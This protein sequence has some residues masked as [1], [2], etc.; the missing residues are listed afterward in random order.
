MPEQTRYR[1]TFD[2]IG[3]THDVAPLDVTLEGPIDLHP[4][5]L[6]E[7]IYDYARPKLASREVDV[8]VTLS[9]DD[10]TG[11]GTI[12]CGMHSGGSFTITIVEVEHGPA[13]T[14]V[15]ASGDRPSDRA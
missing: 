10:N 2:R 14:V 13:E 4:S 8:D 3:R 6:A 7:A 5:R 15:L 12:F 11:T 1:I 9:E